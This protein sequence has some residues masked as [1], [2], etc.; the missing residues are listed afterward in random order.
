MRALSWTMRNR[1]R[2][3]AALRA[4]RR[5]AAPLRW[6]SGTSVRRLPWPMSAWTAARDAPLPPKQTFREW[7]ATRE[8]G[9]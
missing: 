3:A 5:G 1:R 4:A 2:Y 6:A 9:S 7:W 8:R